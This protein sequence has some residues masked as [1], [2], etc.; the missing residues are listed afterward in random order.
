VKYEHQLMHILW[1]A[2]SLL[3]AMFVV[4][5][6]FAQPAAAQ[7]PAVDSPEPQR[8]RVHLDCDDCFSEFIRE[9]IHWVDFVRQPQDA[10]VQ[11]LSS[12]EG[13]GGGGREVVL[14]FVGHGRLA[15]VDQTLRATSEPGASEDA[16]R[17]AIRDVVV[18][19]LLQYLARDG[20]TAGLDLT[21][22]D[23]EPVRAPSPSD[24]WNLWVFSIGADGSRHAEAARHDW[25]ASFEASAD[26]VTQRWKISFG[27]DLEQERETFAIEDGGAPLVVRRH[28]HEFNWFLARSLTDHVSLGLDGD[29]ETS[30]FDNVRWRGR[31]S[32]AIEVNLFPYAQYATRQF[33]I[34]YSIGVR[35]A[36][37]Y[38]LT[39]FNRLKETLGR[40]ELSAT[41]DQRQPWGTLEGR[42][43]WSQYLHDLGLTHLEFDGDASVRVVR[44]LSFDVH[45]SASRIRDQISLPLRG[46]TPEEVLLRLRQLRSGHEIQI[47]FGV[48]Y[49]FG[50]IFNNIVNPRFGTNN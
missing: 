5:P 28:D 35:S 19:G 33:R 26:R 42:V 47:F 17:R 30:T 41:F 13:T 29:L 27:L 1:I 44:G 32:P 15:G 25:E 4:Q 38:E 45:A 46:A 9:E 2:A 20:R 22:D 36:A 31:V 24:P 48:T 23:T 50:S 39:L 16:R 12:R 10:D 14:R 49:T 18:I 21:V 43:E 6:A 7:A 11:I 37:Y 3:L 8:L 34:E 40:H